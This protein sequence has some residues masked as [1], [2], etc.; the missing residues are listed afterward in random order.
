MVEIHCS[1]LSGYNDCPRR[2]APRICRD[3]IEGAGTHTKRERPRIYS[4]VGTACH[5]GSCSLANRK[6]I[7]IPTLDEGETVAI[8]TLRNES[9]DGIE[10]DDVTRN[11]NVAEKQ[12]RRMVGTWFVDLLPELQPEKTE[13]RLSAGVGDDFRLVGSFDLRNVDKSLYD[14]KFGSVWRS[15]RAQLG[16]YS[17]LAKANFKDETPRL[18]GCHIQRVAI[19]KPQP[20]A[21]RMDYGV[22]D[23]EKMAIEACQVIMRDIRAFQKN[24]NPACFPANP[25]SVLCSPK[26]C[27]SFNTEWC[28]AGV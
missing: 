24:G 9:S 22:P 16:G 8:S 27:D 17:I 2:C 25:M 21:A 7:A 10:Y 14:W 18:V 20:G 4:A 12:V 6:M 15:C 5:A 26:F 19:T 3:I 11:M 1:S 28:R 23:S 13:W